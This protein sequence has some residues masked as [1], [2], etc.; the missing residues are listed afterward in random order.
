MKSLFDSHG[1]HITNEVNGQLY[2]PKGKNIGHF[3][4]TYQIFIDMSGHYLGEITH[5]NRLMYRINS[6][7]KNSNHGVYGNFCKYWQLRKSWK[8]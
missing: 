1:Q 3:L 6:P 2:S 7:Y 8:L 4:T 5:S